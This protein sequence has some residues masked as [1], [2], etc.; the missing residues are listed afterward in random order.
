MRCMKSNQ[1]WQYIYPYLSQDTYKGESRYKKKG[2][3]HEAP[4]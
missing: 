1:L 2:A 3:K 4:P